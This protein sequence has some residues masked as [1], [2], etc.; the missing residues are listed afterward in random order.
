VRRWEL[1]QLPDGTE[2]R[3]IPSTRPE[4][5]EEAKGD[6]LVMIWSTTAV[7]SNDAMRQMY[8]HLG[9][10]E[11]RPM[12]RSDGTPYPDDEDDQFAGPDHL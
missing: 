1:W 3:F 10:G 4:Q 11:Y 7:G 2:S 6:G 12:L 8:R 9:W 5:A